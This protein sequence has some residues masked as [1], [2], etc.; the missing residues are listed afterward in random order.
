VRR[1]TLDQGL[2]GMENSG[3]LDNFDSKDVEII[4]SGVALED[5]TVSGSGQLLLGTVRQPE[6]TV[7]VSG[8]GG[9]RA[10][11][12]VER[13]DAHVSGSGGARLSGLAAGLGRITVSGS[14]NVVITALDDARVRV[15][16]SGHVSISDRPRAFFPC[17]IGVRPDR[18][19]RQFLHAAG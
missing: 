18:G 19:G 11:G 4:V 14:G 17:R 13:L 7:N 3:W 9:V 5:V 8:S 12:R 16:G 15:S 1:V 10:E 6:L 2:I